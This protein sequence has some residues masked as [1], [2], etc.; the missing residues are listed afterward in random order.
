MSWKAELIPFVDGVE[1][2]VREKAESSM[3]PPMV[4]AQATGQVGCHLLSSQQGQGR[5]GEIKCFVLV[6]LHLRGLLNIPMKTWAW[7]SDFES[8]FQGRDQ[9]STVITVWIVLKPQERVR[10]PREWV[11]DWHLPA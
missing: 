4:L 8:E 5:F 7:G 10:T 3:A 6:L 1:I 2:R 11:T 9:S